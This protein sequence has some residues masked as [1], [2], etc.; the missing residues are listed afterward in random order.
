MCDTFSRVG[1]LCTYP[2][3]KYCL[4]MVVA[5]FIGEKKWTDLNLNILILQNFILNKKIAILH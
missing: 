2:R 1:K 3:K 4:N 5:V